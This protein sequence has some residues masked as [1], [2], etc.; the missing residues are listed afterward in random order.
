MLA[1]ILGKTGRHDETLQYLGML[2]DRARRDGEANLAVDFAF[3]YLGLGND[4]E[5][6]RY[7][8]MAADARLGSIVFLKASPIWVPLHQHKR[9]RELL[10]RIG[11]E[12]GESGKTPGNGD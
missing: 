1:F 11:F 12:K 2:H 5:A 4:E 6:L 9:F 3:I 10:K 7:L 8:E